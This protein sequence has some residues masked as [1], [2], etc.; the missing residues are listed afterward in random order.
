MLILA[1]R[2]FLA[3]YFADKALKEADDIWDKKTMQQSNNGM[4]Q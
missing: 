2:W 4:A 1:V 3:K